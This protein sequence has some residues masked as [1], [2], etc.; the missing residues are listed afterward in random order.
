MEQI[1]F[2]KMFLMGN[3]EPKII[4]QEQGEK[5]SIALTSMNCPR[6]VMVDSDIIN[7]SSISN[8]E[9]HQKTESKFIEGAVRDVNIIREL[10][11]PEK[12]TH[13][14]YLSLKSGNKQLLLK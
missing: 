6:F 1:F 14:A 11:A 9:I 5:L 2:Y 13:E 4:T 10:T 12:E 3:K 7:T 8:V